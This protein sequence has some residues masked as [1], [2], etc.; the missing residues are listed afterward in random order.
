[1]QIWRSL[2]GVCGHPTRSSPRTLL[3]RWGTVRKSLW[4]VAAVLVAACVALIVWRSGAVMPKVS[5]LPYARTYPIG[6][7]RQDTVA[8]ENRGWVTITVK[9]V[10]PPAGVSD[11]RVHIDHPRIGADERTAIDLSWSL[12]PGTPCGGDNRITVIVRSAVGVDRTV[13][14]TKTWGCADS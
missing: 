5:E 6:E 8:I 13:A 12:E 3:G 14:T 2:F 4:L 1:M 7:K 10:R 11:V 9:G